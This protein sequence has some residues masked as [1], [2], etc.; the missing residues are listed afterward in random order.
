[1]DIPTEKKI[2]AY[3][4]AALAKGADQEDIILKLKNAGVS[5][6]VAEEIIRKIELTQFFDYNEAV[7]SE[8]KQKILNAKEK[9]GGKNQ[10]RVEEIMSSPV[11]T[12]TTKEYLLNAARIMYEKNIG[13]VVVIDPGDANRAV[14]M[15]T[16]RELTKLV[17]ENIDYRN[18][19]A[20]QIMDH[21]LIIASADDPL[22]KIG[23]LMRVNN[24][25]RVIILK[26]GDLVGVITSTELIKLM[27][28]V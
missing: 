15:I 2:E 11:Y 23:T 14:G 21:T 7:Y 26:N 16:S 18:M 19:R 12:V 25:K 28:M 24:V 9:Y 17:A 5:E 3:I 10:I 8:K 13:A 1:M 4:R 20:E 27:A 6:N 22:S